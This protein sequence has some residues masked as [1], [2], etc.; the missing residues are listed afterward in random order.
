MKES[1]NG[2]EQ[3]EKSKTIATLTNLLQEKS[4]E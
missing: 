1:A 3:D 2:D 4:K